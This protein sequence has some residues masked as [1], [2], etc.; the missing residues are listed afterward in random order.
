MFLKALCVL[1]SV[2]IPN[3]L[4]LNNENG[5]SL[6]FGTNTLTLHN[7]VRTFYN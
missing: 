1:H 7:S 3:A 2:N 5:Y 6:S 4:F